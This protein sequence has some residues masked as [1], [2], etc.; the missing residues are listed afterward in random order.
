MVRWA[1]KGTYGSQLAPIEEMGIVISNSQLSI[2]GDLFNGIR[3]LGSW[4][5]VGRPGRLDI[6]SWR[7]SAD[8][9]WF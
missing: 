4:H 2:H 9:G 1:G 6:G 3:V 7:F 8:A 5:W